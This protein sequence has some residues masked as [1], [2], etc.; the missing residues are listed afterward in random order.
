MQE[1]YFTLAVSGLLDMRMRQV[2]S[3]S[4]SIGH[5]SGFVGV[6]V[7]IFPERGD[8][9]EAVSPPLSLPFFLLFYQCDGSLFSFSFRVGAH[10]LVAWICQPYR[11]GLQLGAGCEYW[12]LLDVS[13]TQPP[14]CKAVVKCL[15]VPAC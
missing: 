1:A 13:G 8:S 12:K 10:G 7:S 9:L 3:C 14:L 11:S 4:W 2:S 5:C 15:L 6:V